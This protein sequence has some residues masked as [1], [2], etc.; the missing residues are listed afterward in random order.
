MPALLLAAALAL[1]L[2][3]CVTDGT[4]GKSTQPV[5]TNVPLELPTPVYSEGQ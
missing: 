4:P 2:C 3:G 1:T 5:V